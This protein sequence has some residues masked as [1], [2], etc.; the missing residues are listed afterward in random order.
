M[1]RLHALLAIVFIIGLIMVLT[2]SLSADTNE[3]LEPLS[4]DPPHLYLGGTNS[5]ALC[6]VDYQNKPDP[7]TDDWISF[8]VC[9]SC[10]SLGGTA[11]AA[12]I[13]I[14]P[15][16]TI[17]C[18]NCH[19][20]HHHQAVWPHKYIKS[21]IT[22]PAG[23]T[24]AVVFADSLDFIH[25]A[26]N[27][28]G[29]CETCHTQTNYHRNNASGDHT[30]NVGSDCTTCHPH[31]SSFQANCTSCHGTPGVNAA[32]PVDIYGASDSYEVGKHQEH[33]QVSVDN[34]GSQCALCHYERGPGTGFHTNGNGQ[35][36]VNF[37][38]AAGAS[39]TWTNGVRGSSPG[40]CSN[41]ACHQD[42]NWD[43]QEVG[44]CDM[45]HGA[46]PSSGAHATHFG[47]DVSLASY[48]ST[49]NLSNTSQYIFACGTCHPMSQDMHRNGTVD[50]ELYNSNAPNGSLKS[51]NP[52]TATYTPG[53]VV[54]YDVDSI[55]Y[56]NGTCSDVYCH[57]RTD[58]SSP[59]PISNPTGTD[60]N[61]NLTYD[62]Y[63]VTE[64]RMYASVNWED[65]HINCNGCHRNGPQT[66]YPEVQAG[67][68]NSHAWINESGYEDFHFWNH[69]FDPI[70]CRTCHYS[71]IT[72]T[73]A[74][75]RDA[76]DIT[77]FGGAPLANKAFHVNGNKDVSFDPVDTIV[78]NSNSWVLTDASYDPATKLC[79][80]VPCH[81]N[82]LTPEWGKPY[83]SSISAE[84]NQCHQYKVVEDHGTD[85]TMTL[86]SRSGSF[87]DKCLECHTGHRN[88]KK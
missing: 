28:D 57:S 31:T 27:Y 26:P 82:Q 77:Y 14:V 2:V 5:C 35:A 55:P 88:K 18:E 30:H 29:I 19:N 1:N 85:I 50:V 38:P 46:P 44:G 71:T 58:W 33:L 36:Y 68:G 75:S 9:Q 16:D 40:S 22:T 42:A 39:A 62:P 6:H 54:Y 17:W 70:Q 67:V 66:S 4:L 76:S 83:R 21:E 47:G 23:Q 78:Y 12:D 69:G 53:G 25:G 41:L 45:C 13:H 65:P 86:S 56:T 64:T 34:T 63:V 48:G 10:H 11:T 61:G 74:W 52:S 15:N 51:L 84:C 87:E 20:P 59:D 8:T 80:S 72:A 3:T 7:L 60:A 32:P 24:K 81:L 43:P 73:M 79:S 49:E 37:H